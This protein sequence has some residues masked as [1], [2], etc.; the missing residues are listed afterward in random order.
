[1][2][3]EKDT[4]RKTKKVK[5]PR[6]KAPKVKAEK[7]KEPRVKAEKVKEPKAKAE[8]VK[9]PKVKAQKVKEPKVKA[10]K[11]KEPKVRAEKVKAPRS[12]SGKVKNGKEKPQSEKKRSGVKEG[13]R[14]V[15]LFRSI[16]FRLIASFM[17]PVLGIIVLGVTS[18]QKASDAIINNYQ[19]SV[20]QTMDMM[21]QYV[22]L[23][24]VSEKDEFKSYLNEADLKSYFAGQQSAEVAGSTNKSYMDKIR[25]KMALDSKIS[26]AY[27][28]A[29]NGKSVYVSSITLPENAYSDYTA[30]TQGTKIKED[31]YNWFL[32]GQDPEADEAL[33]IKTDTYSLRLVRNYNEAKAIMM[34]DLDETFVREAMQSMDAGED[35]YVALVTSDGHEFFSDEEIQ[36][37]DPVFFGQDFYNKAI[38]SENISGTETVMV[39]GQEY[40]F[41]YS[42]L[43]DTGAMATALI[44]TARLLAET[45]EI[46]TLS[47]VLILVAVI[48]S[49]LLGILMSGQMSGTIHYILRQLRKVSHGDLTV[50]LTSKKKDEFGL[51][52]DGVN[53]T[54]SHVK[55]L[56]ENVN[57]VSIQL[58]E[59]AA[60]VSEA[61][62]TFMKTSN[63]IQH[64][65]SEIEQGV[66]KLDSGSEDCLNQ[67]DSLSGKITNVSLNADEIGKL[68]ST[69]GETINSGIDS[70][71]GLTSSAES[72]T[73]ITRNVIE[74]IESLEEKSRSISKI[75]SA[76]NDIAEQTNLLSLNAS[77]EAARAGEAGRGFA[78][79]AEE[80]RKLADQC[81]TSAGQIS[82]IIN[83]IMDKTGEV[84]GIAKQ[85]EEVVSTQ[86]GAVE[87]T[88]TSFRMIDSQVESLLKA[89]ETISSN[90]QEMNASRTETLEAIESISAVSAETAACSS[91]VYTTAGTQLNAIEDLDKASQQL[92]DKAEH[93]VEMLGTFTV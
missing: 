7:V 59:T 44:P 35:G 26:A 89:L 61:S 63:D 16:R 24:V 10:G 82:S 51:L 28:L 21:Q 60:Y 9:E 31:I 46:K 77:I 57:E 14:E 93:L 92:R 11:V 4:E 13:K 43:E 45:N 56:I 65:I 2:K 58:N 27:F 17:V 73:R 81:L 29:D 5:E 52:C 15:S 42:K 33:G 75:V 23:V 80:I 69:T 6:V 3:N 12:G 72:T 38:E 22:N 78:V 53:N 25:N 71:Q 32:F 37:E 36:P 68:T 87:D 91:T 55:S 62:G 34:V 40:L 47:V 86:T 74:A 76:I 20:E 19:D 79:V 90:V 70:V 88:T 64:A 84:V 8:K 48:V 83:E 66:N 54:V 30:T 18:Y 49:I 67:M 41:I 85:A 1:M 39:N 50:H